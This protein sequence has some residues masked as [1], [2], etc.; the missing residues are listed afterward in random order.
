MLFIRATAVLHNLARTLNDPRPPDVHDHNDNDG[1]PGDDEDGDGD[2]EQQGQ[3]PL[4]AAAARVAGKLFRNT[5][6][7]Q[8]F[9]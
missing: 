7:R 8:M 5:I 9:P 2:E 3:Q 4:S 1:L 6:F